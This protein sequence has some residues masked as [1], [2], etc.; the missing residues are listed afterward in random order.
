MISAEDLKKKILASTG[1]NGQQIIRRVVVA[2]QQILFDQRTHQQ[3]F[4]GIMEN[5]GKS[6]AH[7][8]LLL[9]DKSRPQGQPAAQPTAP[10]GLINAQAG[11]PQ[12]AVPAAPTSSMPRGALIPAAAVLLANVAEFADKA[13]LKQMDEAEFAS[14]LEEMSVIILDRFNKSFR[15]SVQQ[16]TGKMASGGTPAPGIINNAGGA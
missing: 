12:Q 15:S 11:Q 2:G 16:K 13:G 4:A 10:T 7:L 5:P 1:P 6:V 3:A 8:M 9:Y 14:Q